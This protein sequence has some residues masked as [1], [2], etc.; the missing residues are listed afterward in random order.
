MSNLRSLPALRS[1]RCPP[2][3]FSQKP[4]CFNLLYLALK[5]CGV[6]VRH[7]DKIEICD[8]NRI[9]IGSFNE[10]QIF[11]EKVKEILEKLK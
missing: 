11:I 6:L 4:C 5:S 8:Y 3:L 2:M 7:F 9:T 10:M 1:Y